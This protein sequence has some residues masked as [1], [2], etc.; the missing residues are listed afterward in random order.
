VKTDQD[1]V[2][3]WLEAM[4]TEVRCQTC[5][6]F[7]HGACLSWAPLHCPAVR[8]TLDANVQ[9]DGDVPNRA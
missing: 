8:E 6:L 9:S 1:L 2:D 7:K 5:G 3:L 4:R